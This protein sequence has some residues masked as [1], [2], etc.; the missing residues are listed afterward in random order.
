[1][2]CHNSDERKELAERAAKTSDAALAVAETL[3]AAAS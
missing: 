3:A 2:R 1:M